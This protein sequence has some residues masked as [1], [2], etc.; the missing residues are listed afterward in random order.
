MLGLVCPVRAPPPIW[1]VMSNCWP[2]WRPWAD[3]MPSVLYARA[4]VS[5][6]ACFIRRPVARISKPVYPHS[7]HV[8]RRP[9]GFPVRIP[10]PC[11]TCIDEQSRVRPILHPIFSIH[12][13][14]PV[15]P[16]SRFQA[17]VRSSSR[18]MTAGAVCGG[19]RAGGGEGGGDGGAEGGD[20][21]LATGVLDDCMIVSPESQPDA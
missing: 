13:S 6:G 14:V 9:V 21:G 18:S 5:R 1:Q 20:A 8:D 7:A 16:G 19:G 2:H 10:F 15:R 12:F 4:S 17:C 11:G 3:A